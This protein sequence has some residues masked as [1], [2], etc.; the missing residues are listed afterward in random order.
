MRKCRLFQ[1]GTEELYESSCGVL[2]VSHG[3]SEEL[4]SRFWVM[5]VVAS[6]VEL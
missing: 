6:G 2:R 4:R 3:S 1:V 5:P